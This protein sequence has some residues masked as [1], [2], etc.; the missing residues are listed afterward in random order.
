[1]GILRIILEENKKTFVNLR[2]FYKVF[3]SVDGDTIW[4]IFNEI[5]VRGD[6]VMRN[7]DEKFDIN[8]KI[9]VH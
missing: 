2:D 5:S 8:W 3:G 1:M 6:W 7:T 4:E 9:F